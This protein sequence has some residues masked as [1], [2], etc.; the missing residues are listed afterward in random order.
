ME[1]IGHVDREG[2]TSFRVEWRLQH[3]LHLRVTLAGT[4]F[5]SSKAKG[6]GETAR[7]GGIWFYVPGSIFLG[8]AATIRA[9]KI[10]LLI[11]LNDKGSL[12]DAADQPI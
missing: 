4:N 7:L 1:S 2:G 11:Q 8:Q 5:G 3:T 6:N 10:T 12:S 9:V